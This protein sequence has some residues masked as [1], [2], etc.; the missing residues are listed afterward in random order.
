[1]EELLYCGGEPAQ[2]AQ[3]D[4]GVLTMRDVQKLLGPARKVGPD[5][6]QRFLPSERF[7]ILVLPV[8]FFISSSKVVSKTCSN[9]LGY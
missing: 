6:L 1:M 5:D 2:V 9:K 8:F 7:M 4:C 3:G